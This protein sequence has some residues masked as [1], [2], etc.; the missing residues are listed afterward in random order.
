MPRR[1]W[2][3]DELILAFN[4]Y[5]KTPFGRIHNRNPE[6]ISLAKNL[7]R[8]SS[9]VSWKLA[10]FARLD[11]SLSLRSIKGAAHGGKLEIS[12]WNEFSGD[13]EKLG[14]ESELLLAKLTGKRIEEIADIDGETLPPEGKE[15]EAIVRLRVNQNFFR[16]SVLAA[17]GCKCCISGIRSPEL[18]TASHIV[19]WSFDKKNRL[20]PR[21]GLCLSALHD[22]AFDRGLLTI[23]PN[24]TVSIA[25]ELKKARKNLA[26]QQFFLQYDGT[27]ITLPDRFVPDLELIRFHNQNVFRH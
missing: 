23:L 18:L 10:N 1:D 7:R 8:T 3:R 6:I 14:Y 13:W 17:Y 2:S 4:L 22:R 20:N 5:C 19:P 15:R 16:S 21:N 11:P 24:L 9:A 27:K 25:S 26:T 12:I